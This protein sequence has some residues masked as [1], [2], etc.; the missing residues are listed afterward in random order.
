MSGDCKLEYG[1]KEIERDFDAGLS[2]DYIVHHY[3][4]SKKS[5]RR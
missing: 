5:R 4:N 3:R 1:V 2:I